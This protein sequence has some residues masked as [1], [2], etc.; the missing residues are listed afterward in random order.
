MGMLTGLMRASPRPEDEFRDLIA[1]RGPRWQAACLRITRD[2][3]LAEDA[4]QEALLKAWRA[5]DQFRGEAERDTWVH[6]IAVNAALELLRRRGPLAE[7]PGPADGP[8]VA[9]IDDPARAHLR[10]AFGS[11][12]GAAMARLSEFERVCFVLKHLE[13]WKLE[14]IATH[15]DRSVNSIKQALFRAVGKL[16]EDLA[17]WQEDPR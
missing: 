15:F 7:D 12:T 17:H 6:R 16:R 13:Q 4:V 10:G 11:E 14:E 8:E 2:P 5:R 9:D 1:R 3:A